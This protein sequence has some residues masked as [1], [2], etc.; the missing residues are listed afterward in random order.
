MNNKGGEERFFYTATKVWILK[1][2]GI[3]V[4]YTA[5]KVWILKV[6]RIWFVYTATKV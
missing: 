4:V 2:G 6:G 3:G 5:T 1:V